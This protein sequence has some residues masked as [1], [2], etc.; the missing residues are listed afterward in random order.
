MSTPASG[1]ARNVVLVHGGFVDGS[2]WQGVYDILAKDGFSVGAVQN[3]TLSLTGDAAATRQVI[4]AQ[5]GPVVLA[6]AE[7]DVLG[8][9]AAGLFGDQVLDEAST[10]H[11]SG[12]EAAGGLRVHVGT[13]APAI[14]RGR[15]AQAELVF[16]DMRRRIDLD[17]QGPP[18]GDPHGRAIRRRGCR[19]SHRVRCPLS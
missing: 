1:P 18:Q 19:V 5:P 3:P 6:G 13:A 8:D 15:Q 2:G 10:G 17:V 4:D 9:A 11:D 16:E 14:A 7:N 12:P